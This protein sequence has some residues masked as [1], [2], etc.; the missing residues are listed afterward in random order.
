M[1]N[2]FAY[3]MLAIWP[4]VTLVLFRQMPPARAFVMAMVAGYLLLPPAPAS[5][6]FPLLPPLGK[7]AIPTP[8]V[9]LA[10]GLT[11][12]W[13]AGL[14]PRSTM[15]RVL[16][17]VFV[18]APF[19]TYVTNRE[20]VFFGPIGLPGMRPFEALA[21]AVQNVPVVLVFLLARS[22]L[23][24]SADNDTNAGL[25]LIVLALFVGGLA[26]SLPMLV[27]VRLSPQ[28]NR[29]IYGYYQH[30]FAQTMRG[31]GFRPLVFLNHGLWAAFFAMMAVVAAVALWRNETSENR[32]L[33]LLAAGYLG[34]VLVLCKSLGALAYGLVLVPVTAFVQPRRQITIAV[35]LATLAV[36]YPLVRSAGLAPGNWL[37][38]QAA[39]I[40]PERANSLQF[41]L[42]NEAIL[43]ERAREKPAFGW[44]IWGRNQIIDPASGTFATITDG[45]WIIT[46]GVYGWLGYLAEFGLLFWPLV[47]LWR[48][49]RRPGAEMPALV[50][51]VAL[52]LAINLI[53]LLPNATLTP[54]TW[55]IAGA[56]LGTAE[57]AHTRQPAPKA[58][59]MRTVL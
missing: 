48:T 13:P 11:G 36:S 8:S 19:L 34:A 10:L 37:V 41:R 59:L 2:L 45:R 14:M 53:D 18:L 27:E 52:I 24:G 4:V 44:C 12:Q 31:G 3:F 42:D 20:P 47:L 57:R 17:A 51:P 30:D 49:A 50:G 5:F 54:L 21:L 39:R 26:Y 22:L 7:S 43:L 46:L 58:P 23:T 35:L 6:D 1:P 55:L 28:I 15:V 25:R 40:S 33:Y 38:G 56:I 9:L 29:W 16:I 32:G